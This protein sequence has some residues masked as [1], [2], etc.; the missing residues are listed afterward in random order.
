MA[1]E[2]EGRRQGRVPDHLIV[3]E[4]A[5][6]DRNEEVETLTGEIPIDLEASSRV[7]DLTIWYLKIKGLFYIL[8]GITWVVF[9]SPG[10]LA[11]IEWVEF[12]TGNMV[13]IIWIVSGV[14]PIVVSFID[15]DKAHRL[16]F[17]L[18]IVTPMVLGS[19]FFISWIISYVPAMEQ[20]GY[21]RAGIV[22]VS[23]WAY[24]ASAYLVSRVYSITK[25]AKDL[26][27]MEVP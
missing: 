7:N 5:M 27:L 9:Q 20:L 8:I 16:G 26:N 2:C 12:L 17:F 19:Y 11:G 18:L 23:Y 25:P 15:R 21:N 3:K 24:S 10:R 14:I 6:D 4:A 1:T 22:T 13:G